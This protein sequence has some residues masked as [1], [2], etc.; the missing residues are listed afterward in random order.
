MHRSHGSPS[1]GSDRAD[2]YG[3]YARRDLYTF[4]GQTKERAYCAEK[5][6]CLVPLLVTIQQPKLFQEKKKEN[7]ILDQAIEPSQCTCDAMAMMDARLVKN[8]NSDAAS[9]DTR[10]NSGILSFTFFK[11]IQFLYRYRLALSFTFT[12]EGDYYLKKSR[13]VI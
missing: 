5:G 10:D 13:C 4:Q 9:G 12:T 3:W 8:R 11:L 1:R 6:T 7:S 2:G